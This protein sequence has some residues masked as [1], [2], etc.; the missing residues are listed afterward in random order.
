MSGGSA[1]GT[2]F[3]RLGIDSSQF[4]SGL[5]TAGTSLAT[6][7]NRVKEKIDPA[8][9]TVEKASR[10]VGTLATVAQGGLP[11][12]E[13][14]AATLGP[15]GIAAGALV[16]VYKTLNPLVAEYFKAT[17]DAKTVNEEIASAM[18]GNATATATTV[19][20]V[21]QLAQKM[22]LV[23]PQ[24]A[25]LA[26]KTKAG[27]ALTKQ[28][29]E[30]LAIM[31]DYVNQEAVARTKSAQ[32]TAKARE[33][34]A[35]LEQEIKSRALPTS[36][37]I[38]LATAAA[39]KEHLALG[40]AARKTYG[41]LTQGEA[42]KAVEDLANAM[43]AAVASGAS[44]Q[45]VAEKMGPAFGAAFTEAQ[46]LGVDMTGK[47]TSLKTAIEGGDTAMLTKLL[48]SLGRLAEEAKTGTE[49]SKKYLDEMGERLKG[50]LSGGFGR[51]I[52]EGTNA[53]K[54]ALDQ[55]Y[56]ETGDRI[57]PIKIDVPGL[58]RQVEDAVSGAL[59]KT[60]GRV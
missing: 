25:D 54:Q 38:A 55:F 45:Q 14:Y 11:A 21:G 57:W 39:A 23:L 35:R 13:A 44:V 43:Q 16:L 47:F 17:L 40:E 42:R 20:Q 6:F 51:G 2:I 18:V 31:T 33:E 24:Y 10:A 22:G 4:Q 37:Q 50:S 30:T 32:A 8:A 3:A 19:D 46:K 58:Q 41:I 5:S 34:A 59:Q 26:A 29:A 53:G 12:L 27:I 36:V 52:E 60:A 56:R 49:A 15:V 28:E 1:L 48:P 7:G 9:Y